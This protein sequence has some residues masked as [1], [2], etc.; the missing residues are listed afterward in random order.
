[1]HIFYQFVKYTKR[2]A[3]AV[4][5]AFMLGMNNVYKEE[6]KSPDDIVLS[7]VEDDVQEDSAPKD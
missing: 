5:V 7:V 2:V 4:I 3:W 1:M 6:E